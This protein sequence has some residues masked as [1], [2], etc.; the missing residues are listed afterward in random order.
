MRQWLR[1]ERR[2]AARWTACAGIGTIGLLL[3]WP[4]SAHALMVSDD[5]SSYAIGPDGLHGE[6]IHG[7]GNWTSS[8]TR[9]GRGWEVN[10]GPGRKNIAYWP[11][12]WQAFP[13]GE[14]VA[15]FHVSSPVAIE[16]L[17]LTIEYLIQSNGGLRVSLSGDHLHWQDITAPLG[18][19]ASNATFQLSSADLSALIDAAAITTELYIRFESA[20]SA[21][22]NWFV[23]VSYVAARINERP[24]GVEKLL[25]RSSRAAAAG[26]NQF[27]LWMMNPDGTALEQLTFGDVSDHR[28]EVSAD[29]TTVLFYRYA[30]AP[31]ATDCHTSVWTLNLLSRTEIPITPGIDYPQDPQSLLASFGPTWSPHG[32]QIAFVRAT[33][34]GSCLGH[35]PGTARLW[36]LP[37][38]PTDPLAPVQVSPAAGASR[39]WPSWAPDGTQ[40]LYNQEVDGVNPFT[41]YRL[42]LA[43]GTEEEVIPYVHG[44]YFPRYAPH[45]RKI[46]WTSYRNG[47]DGDIYVTD[48]ADPAGAQVRATPSSHFSSSAWSPDGR[49]L[50]F[51]S[52]AGPGNRDI[53]TANADGSAL[54]PVTADGSDDAD[55]WWARVRRAPQADAGHDHTVHVGSLVTLDGSHSTDPDG[56]YPLTYAWTITEK[57]SGSAAALSDPAAVHPTFVADVT[58]DFLV[59]LRVTNHSGFSSADDQTRISTQNSAPV[60]DAGSGA[61]THPDHGVSLD[62]SGSFDPDGDL[63]TY[64]WTLAAQPDGSAAALS[65]ADT[66]T[67]TLI[68]DLPGEYA[69]QLMVTDQWGLAS[70]PDGVTI[71]TTNTMPAADAGPDQSVIVLGSTV[72]LDGTQSY[73]LDGDPITHAWRLTTVPSGSQAMLDDAGSQTPRFVADVH[74]TSVA[75]LL[76][77]DPWSQSAPDTVAVGFENIR[78]V[79]DA[80]QNQSVVQQDRVYLD[81][82]GSHDANGDRL[83]FRWSLVSAPQGSQ[84]ALSDP[85]AVNPSY[86]AD[87][88]GAYIAQLIVDDGFVDSE[89]STASAFVVSFQDAATQALQE[90]IAAING[91]DPAV[92]TNAN[93]QNALTNQ[94]GAILGKIAGGD[95]EGALNQLT[96]AV[97]KRVDGCEAEDAPDR[98]DWVTTC[99]AQA[100]VYPL[101]V[102]AQHYLEDVL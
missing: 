52:V 85:S 26:T 99:T 47:G 39:L 58:G 50:V 12:P 71:S 95:Y 61:T 59:S 5:F 66:A 21:G 65:H 63:L 23:H 51:I 16:H 24:L 35:V 42:L 75:E 18:L 87:L 83:T 17:E 34:P 9:F 100:N 69:V 13:F 93:L 6:L 7:L 43:D 37:Y 82:S 54:T 57:P 77:S 64:Q 62:G 67:S 32:D 31:A 19:V 40:L 73:D 98:T 68:P 33:V 11:S 94:I 25:F 70:D 27:H 45:G 1:H 22:T 92:F 97:L 78:P 91:L 56:D 4:A 48:V 41:V 3:A 46:T 38:P 86:D 20:G 8:D 14:N 60:A 28:P 36:T 88:P 55:P 76:V 79:A 80:G 72:Q 102:Q 29:G 74:G 53:T 84:A 89:P 2:R 90:A 101:L 96:H 49:K 44:E 15:T 10:A 30:P 81:G